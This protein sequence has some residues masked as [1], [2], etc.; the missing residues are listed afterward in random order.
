MH[1]KKMCGVE[2]FKI[3]DKVENE[4]HFIEF[5]KGFSKICDSSTFRILNSD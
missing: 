4:D 5:I 2:Q 1:K 3:Y